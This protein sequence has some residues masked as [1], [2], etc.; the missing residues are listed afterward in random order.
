MDI[1][2]GRTSSPRH[3]ALCGAKTQSHREGHT[4]QAGSTALGDKACSPAP[5]GA[6]PLL[7]CNQLSVCC[8]PCPA[9]QPHQGAQRRAAD[10]VLSASLEVTK[11][12]SVRKARWSQPHTSQ[13]RLRGRGSA[14][15]APS[16]PGF[17]ISFLPCPG[18]LPS[19]L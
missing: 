19:Q 2:K 15:A 10:G 7:A 13:L 6:A 11:E 12:Q 9:A 5:C 17:N 3:S 18:L 14:S 4:P 1:E 8:P 16:L